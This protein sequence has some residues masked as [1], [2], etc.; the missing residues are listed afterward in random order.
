ME[1]CQSC[2]YFMPQPAQ[3]GLCRRSPPTV[4]VYPDESS[5]SVFPSMLADGWC[6]EFAKKEIPQ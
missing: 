3:Q 5:F 1:A 6:G 4:L 2:K